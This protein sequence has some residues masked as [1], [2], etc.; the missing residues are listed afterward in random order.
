M[1]YKDARDQFLDWGGWQPN[2]TKAYRSDLQMIASLIG[3][4]DKITLK[5]FTRDA[6]RKAF[7]TYRKG[8]A[9]A[10]VA[11]VRATWR[12]FFDYLTDEGVV[13]GS[14]MGAIRKVKLGKRL[15]KPLKGW[16]EDLDYKLLTALRDGCR[17]GRN[18]FPWLDVAIVATLLATGLRAEEFCSLNIGSIEGR[19]PDQKIYVIGKGNKERTVPVEP[20]LDDT[21]GTYLEERRLLYPTWQPKDSDPLFIAYRPGEPKTGGDRINTNQ[22]D[23]ML[24]TA[25]KSAGFGHAA[26]RGTMAHAFRH[27]YGTTLVAKG[28]SLMAVRKLMG[29]DSVGTTELYVDLVAEEQRMAAGV[30]TV[31]DALTRLTS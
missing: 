15:P 18:P 10:T 16:N 29:H 8:K 26:H 19:R 24:R 27:T 22:L 28:A 11:R 30:N 12:L 25:L 23:Y 31:Y 7:G 21:L 5:V 2:S 9:D 14:P 1:K 20:A 3:D 6:I 4:P 17:K 13:A